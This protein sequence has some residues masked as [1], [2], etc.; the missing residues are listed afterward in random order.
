M[1]HR[2]HGRL[3]WYDGSKGYGEIIYEN[4][5]DPIFYDHSLQNLGRGG[6]E[7]GQPMTF[8][9]KF[10]QRGFEAVNVRIEA[11]APQTQA[12]T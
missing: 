6:L 9:I 10:T 5:P 12:Q 1:S 4:G 11:A 3:K 2:Y 7:I 8:E